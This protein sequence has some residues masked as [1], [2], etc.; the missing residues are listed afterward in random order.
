MSEADLV[1]ESEKFERAQRIIFGPDPYY[2]EEEIEAY[3]ILE[4]GRVEIAEYLRK[5]ADT[6][7]NRLLNVEK[8][9]LNHIYSGLYHYKNISDD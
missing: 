7:N 4:D 1:K 6:G 8:G 9:K 5:I 2:M 3:E